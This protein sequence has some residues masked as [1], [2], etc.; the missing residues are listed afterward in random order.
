MV[1]RLRAPRVIRRHPPGVMHAHPFLRMLWPVDAASYE[2]RVRGQV[3]EA[4]LR[5]FDPL[6]SDIKQVETVL[7]GPVRDQAELHGLLDRL[8]ALGL[9]L[10][11]VRRL[12]D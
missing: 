10:V 5:T 7:H 4:V 11:E 8:Q 1:L 12:P 9:E 2:I 3:S 6:D